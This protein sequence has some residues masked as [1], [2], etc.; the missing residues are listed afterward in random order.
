MDGYEVDGYEVDGCD[1]FLRACVRVCLKQKP[2]KTQPNYFGSW[3]QKI[4]R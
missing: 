3:F 1:L 2:N 4:D